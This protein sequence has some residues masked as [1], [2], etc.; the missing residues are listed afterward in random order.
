MIH[1]QF[2]PLLE[3]R[4]NSLIDLQHSLGMEDAITPTN[5]E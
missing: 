4:K 3:S 5:I 2:R 1:P